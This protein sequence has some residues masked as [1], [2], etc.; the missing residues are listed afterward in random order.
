MFCIN[1][2]FSVVMAQSNASACVDSDGDGYG[3][4]GV[5]TCL[6]GQGQ[7][8]GQAL[9]PAQGSGACI[10]EDGDGYGWDGQNS[11]L[12]VAP[13]TAGACIDD[14]GDGY[15]WDGQQS[16]LV[17]STPAAAQAV[18]TQVVTTQSE[19]AQ[20]PASPGEFHN[21]LPYP[22]RSGFD[23]KS[24]QTD[25]WPNKQELLDAN[26]AGVAV[27]L[28]WAIWQ[29][30]QTS[31]C[32]SSQIR[33][34]NQCFTI[35]SAFDQKI[36]FWSEQGKT[37]TGVLYGVPSWARDN[38]L[39]TATSEDRA[40]FCSARNANDYARFVGMIAE[41][42][43]GL[44]GN[45]HVVDFVIHNEVNLNQWYKVE[46]GAGI[47]CDPNQWIANY[48]A[49]YNAAYDQVIAVQPEARVLVSFAHHFDTVF[50]NPSSNNP[51]M[52]VKTFIRGIH[53]R[54]GGRTWRIA[55]HPYHRNL[56][57]AEASFDDLPQVTFGNIG[58]IAGWLRREFPS[59]PESWE[60]HL[61][62]NGV[63]SNGQSNEFSQDIAVCNSYRNVLGTP[64]MENYIYHRMQDHPL[65]VSGGA[66]LGLR[67]A[68]GSAK[69]VWN[70]WANMSGRGNQRN[71][72][73]CGF[74]N[75]PYIKLTSS[76]GTS[77]EYRASSRVVGDRYSSV[78]NWFLLREPEANTQMAYECQSGASSYVSRDTYCGGALSYG[79]VGYVYN[80]PAANRV[81]LYT[82]RDNGNLISSDEANCG[83]ADVVEFIG[84][85]RKN[86]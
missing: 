14:D 18:T 46:C 3:W 34:D 6:I 57:S 67:R 17:S 19:P 37:V 79:P 40:I 84:Y 20:A 13:Q 27:N 78:D 10:D 51:T 23:I 77:G 5:E 2:L 43:N 39:C 75:L 82:C 35:P 7:T 44:N 76:I 42:Y 32:S 47:P 36:R 1:A 21:A 25:F 26:A 31:N 8:Q 66:A 61:T 80:A 64:G 11:C 12:V 69:P 83:S 70:T 15:G 74:E 50:D 56:S 68:D 58:V 28:V 16:C 29:P 71:N 49:N 86:R 4:N 81:P 22:D 73:D 53:A 72:L 38:S 24:I 33:F 59:Q 45:G 30:T 41:R 48:S 55:Y 9:N 62:E 85:V 65:E 52:S 63:S 60:V 54:A